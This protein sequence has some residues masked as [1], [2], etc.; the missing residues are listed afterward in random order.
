[1]DN[2]ND[3]FK[4]K[5]FI[6]ILYNSYVKYIIY[7]ARSSKKVDYFHNK[8]KEIIET[9]FIDKNKYIINLEYNIP[10]YNSSGKKKCD[11]VILK[12]NIPYI[13]FPIKLIMSN[14]KQNKNNSWENLT[15]EL[16]H[17]KWMN[18]NIHI[19]PIN[20]F[21]NKTPYLN[22]KKIITKFENILIDDLKNY[23]ILIEKG[24]CYDII[25]YII[26]VEHTNNINETFSKIPIILGFN[27]NTKFRTFENILKN[28]I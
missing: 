17:I 8:I 25:T 6:F 10:S 18:N 7:G 13:I 23:N 21:M 3:V 2:L 20:I 1:M 16:Q 15:G 12:N 24:I 26:D 22:D 27:K 19:I 28:L 4:S 11:I 14:Y 5:Y 9:I